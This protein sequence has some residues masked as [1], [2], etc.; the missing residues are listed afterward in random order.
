MSDSNCKSLASGD[1]KHIEVLFNEITSLCRQIGHLSDSMAS[2]ALDPDAVESI[3]HLSNLA[4]MYADMGVQKFGPGC[5]GGPAEWLYPAALSD[6][7]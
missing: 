7:A 6:Q 3:H 4:G 2:G 5:V 1:V